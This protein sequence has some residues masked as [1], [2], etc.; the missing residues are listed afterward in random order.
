MGLRFVS[1][2]EM[3][4]TKEE[5]EAELIKAVNEKLDTRL[6]DEI[7]S[8]KRHSL[9]YDCWCCGDPVDLALSLCINC[10]EK[11]IRQY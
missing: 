1:A 9:V 6:Q 2:E 7:D 3:F 5:F 8:R 4:M 10:E 11:E